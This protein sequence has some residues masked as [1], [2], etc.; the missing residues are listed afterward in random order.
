MSVQTDKKQNTQHKRSEINLIRCILS[1]GRGRREER[2]RLSSMW[3]ATSSSELNININS[4]L[5]YT[6]GLY[7]IFSSAEIRKTT[8][9][10]FSSLYK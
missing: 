6:T 3:Y 5:F 10:S 8:F 4:D 2:E 7:D 1:T 9:K